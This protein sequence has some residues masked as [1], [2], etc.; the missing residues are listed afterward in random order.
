MV[1]LLCYARIIKYFE[2]YEYQIKIQTD[3]KTPVQFMYFLISSLYY[4]FIP[5]FI[6]ALRPLRSPQNEYVFQSV[7]YFGSS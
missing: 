6:M 1:A 3:I 5:I 7:F 4:F 2:S